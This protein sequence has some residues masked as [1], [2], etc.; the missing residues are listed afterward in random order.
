MGP[1]PSKWAAS[2]P[3]NSVVA[4]YL[5]GNRSCSEPVAYK[6][7]PNAQTTRRNQHMPVMAEYVSLSTTSEATSREATQTAMPNH[8][9]TLTPL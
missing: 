4:K 7:S 6:I 9:P 3:R 1:S 5:K 8:G 2:S